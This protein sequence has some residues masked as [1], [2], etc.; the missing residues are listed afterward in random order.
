MINSFLCRMHDTKAGVRGS[1]EWARR[2]GE[3]GGG[4]EEGSGGPGGARG[5]A[6]PGGPGDRLWSVNN[7]IIVNSPLLKVE[8]ST[9]EIN[10]GG[11]S[12]PSY[13]S[14][15]LTQSVLRG[16]SGTIR[17][18]KQRDRGKLRSGGERPCSLAISLVQD[19]FQHRIPV[20]LA[21]GCM[22]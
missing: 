3:G 1:G 15:H 21:G 14:S 17:G 4:T 9:R 6:G 22:C 5:L 7:T 16:H 11:R 12:A 2:S 8:V 20:S 13:L 10:E 18:R 19:R